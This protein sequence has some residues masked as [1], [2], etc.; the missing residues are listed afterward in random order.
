MVLGRPLEGCRKLLA[1][2]G[3]V[4]PVSYEAVPDENLCN[5]WKCGDLVGQAA[6]AAVLP[7]RT[8]NFQTLPTQRRCV[9]REG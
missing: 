8:A 3:F 4:I 7:Y 2:S 6:C 5:S 1:D 9:C